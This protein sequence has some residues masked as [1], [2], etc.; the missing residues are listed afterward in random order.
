MTEA[1]GSITTP[2]PNSSGEDPDSYDLMLS[3]TPLG[4]TQKCMEVLYD[5]LKLR[6]I[7]SGEEA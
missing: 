3:S 1:E 2:T 5:Y 6:G 7:V 4:S